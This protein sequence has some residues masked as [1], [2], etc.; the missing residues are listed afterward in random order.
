VS[1]PSAWLDTA[2]AEVATDP[3]RIRAL[4]PA[5]SRNVGRQDGVDDAA[6]VE[7]LVVLPLRG[8]ALV[9][10]LTGLYRFGDPHEKRGVLRALH[11]LDGPYGGGGIGAAG[12]P[13]LLDALRSNDT[14]LIEAAV[15]QYGAERLDAAAWRQAVL[16]CVFTGVPLSAVNRLLERADGELARMLVDF[17]RER[18]AAGRA[19]PPDVWLVLDHHPAAVAASDLPAGLRPRHRLEA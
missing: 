10:E 12:V 6:R 15:G 2:R 3:A 1:A 16:K 11:M 5:V 4:F 19:V 17:A 9:D 18:V 8:Q 13:L 14:R 7:L